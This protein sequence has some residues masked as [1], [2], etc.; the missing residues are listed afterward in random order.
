MK[1]SGLVVN[2]E[3]SCIWFSRNCEEKCIHD[4]LREMNT[5]RTEDNEKYL[6]VY[7]NQ[8]PIY[9]DLTHNLFLSKIHKKMTR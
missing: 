8:P 5:R 2:P 4:V 9:N 1:V 7:I 3:K 6:G